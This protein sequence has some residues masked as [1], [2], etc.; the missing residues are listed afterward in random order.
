MKQYQLVLVNLSPTLGSEISKTR[1]C[2]ILSPDEMNRHLATIVIAPIISTDKSYPTRVF[3]SNEKYKGWVALDQIRTISK[4][5]IL[6]LDGSISG[7]E[8]STI[9]QVL[10]ETFVD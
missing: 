6:S 4:Q 3:V 5:R 9:K 7:I 1:P 2:L 8:I 10:K